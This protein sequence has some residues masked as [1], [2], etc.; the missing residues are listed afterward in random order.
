MGR[1][2]GKKVNAWW[3]YTLTGEACTIGTF[4]NTSTHAFNPSGVE[5]KGNDWVLVLDDAAMKFKKLGVSI[6]ENK[7]QISC[8]NKKTP[9]IQFCKKP[10][11][12]KLSMQ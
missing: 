11:R 6:Y 12:P 2:S 7:I 1:I 10:L 9:K 8:F 3:Y 5:F 4:S